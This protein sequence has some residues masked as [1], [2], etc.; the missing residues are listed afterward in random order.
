MNPVEW[1][2]YAAAWDLWLGP[3]SLPGMDPL[4]FAVALVL[5]EGDRRIH[6]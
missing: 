2:V 5:A 4:A 1:L 6:E 3:R